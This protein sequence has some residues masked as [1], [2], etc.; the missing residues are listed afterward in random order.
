MLEKRSLKN[1]NG[2]DKRDSDSISLG[3]VFGQI[4]RLLMGDDDDAVFSCSRDVVEGE[5]EEE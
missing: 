1:S 3:K 4:I 2:R 5:G